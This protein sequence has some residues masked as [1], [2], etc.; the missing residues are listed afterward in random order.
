MWNQTKYKDSK[1]LINSLNIF[2]S[3]IPN[4]L[5]VTISQNR[6][7][8]DR[9]DFPT[10]LLTKETSLYVITGQTLGCSFK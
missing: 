10:F 2:R 1:L 8:C 3:K 5:L 7:Y 4:L 6:F 9:L